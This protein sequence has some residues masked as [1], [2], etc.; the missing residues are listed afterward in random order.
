[1]IEEWRDIPDYEGEYSVSSFGRVRSIE[2]TVQR[3]GYPLAIRG[4][5]L[6]QH[7]INT[8]RLI[9]VLSKNGKGKKYLVHRLVAAAF[10]DNPNSLP[11]INHIDGNPKNNRVDNL[12]WCDQHWQEVHKIYN[13]GVNN[14]SLLAQPR[15]V[16]CTETGK[17]Y[18]SL[19]E[20]CRFTGTPLHILFQRLRSGKPDNNGFHWEY[21]IN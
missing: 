11:Q 9:V 7:L 12:E 19:G 16:I 17:V 13:L 15:K 20:A 2:R 21:V 6:K 8:G 5:E 10:L 14:P 18:R 3:N 4:R 1:M